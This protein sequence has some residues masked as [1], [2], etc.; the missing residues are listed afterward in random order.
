[1]AIEPVKTGK[2][3]KDEQATFVVHVKYQQNTTWQGS[4][5]WLDRKKSQQFRSTLELIKL[6][7]EALADRRNNEESINWDTALDNETEMP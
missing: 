6:M 1:M 3:E 5:Q 7:D 4:I 2:E